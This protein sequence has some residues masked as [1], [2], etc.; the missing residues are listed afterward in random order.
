MPGSIFGSIS[1]IE[2]EILPI[3]ADGEPL[4][5]YT[6]SS[7]APELLEADIADDGSLCLTWL[8]PFGGNPIAVTITYKDV[9]YT[10]Y[11]VDSTWVPN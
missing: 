8:K 1:S 4:S 6:V 11:C 5:D 9:D 2:T 10:Y 7:E 3:S